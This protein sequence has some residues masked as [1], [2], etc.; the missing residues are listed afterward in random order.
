MSS[1]PPP[2]HLELTSLKRNFTQRSAS[3]HMQR[4]HSERG[5]LSI[6]MDDALDRELSDDDIKEKLKQF[7]E[8]GGRYEYSEE[9][10]NHLDMKYW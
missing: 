9:R 6:D 1:P 8:E 5:Q 10:R 3:Y 4:Y 7:R 2:P